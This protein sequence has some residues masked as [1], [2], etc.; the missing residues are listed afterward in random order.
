[1]GILKKLGK[2]TNNP[3]VFTANDTENPYA[4]KE[5]MDTGVYALNAILSDG[6]I[7]KGIPKGKRI[8]FYG[9]SGVAKS[10]LTMYVAKAFLEEN[11]KN[12]LIVFETE[13]ATILE[14]AKSIGLDLER[15]GVIPVN[16]VEDF[17]FD[18]NKIIEEIKKER[19]N[20][21]PEEY[22]NYC[23]LLDSLGMLS[24]TK[25]IGDA[26]AG[27]D[28]R[29]MTRAQQVRAVFR[30]IT[31]DLSLLNIPMLIVSHSYNSMNMYSP[32]VV[33]GGGGILYASD[34]IVNL[35][36]AKEKE[37]NERIGSI[38]TLKTL[39]SRFAREE[40]KVKLLLL[41]GKGL[42]KYS[43]LLEYGLE[44]GVIKKEGMSYVFPDGQKAMKKKIVK[45]ASTFWNE[46]N[47]NAL[48]DAIINDLS[49]TSF[50]TEV[51]DDDIDEM[52]EEE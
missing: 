17:K 48:R 20:K 3:Y 27:K 30:T 6:D 28:T 46:H 40:K 11:P 16:T 4:V 50:S 23:F 34:V 35:T 36:K 32:Q 15:V 12:E 24:T 45:E 31:L 14:M 44:L 22:T 49:L 13:G 2:I 37:G 26:K 8:T 29:D 43:Y 52:T 21:K 51:T 9:E 7:F 25:E 33:T 39:K 18:V 5:Y 19:E 38:I 1:M 47:L 42:Y 10:Y 41:Y